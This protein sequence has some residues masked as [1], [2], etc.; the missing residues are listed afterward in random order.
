MIAV[1]IIGILAAT[2]IPKYLQYVLRSR[3]TEGLTMMAMAKNAEY[4]FFALNDCFVNVE[5]TP[6]GGTPSNVRQAWNSVPSG[7]VQLECSNPAPRSFDDLAVRPNY[8][9]VYYEYECRSR[10]SGPGGQTDEF[11][12]SAWGDLDGDGVFYELVYGTDF[13]NDNRTIPS[14]HGTVSFF[15]NDPVRISVGIY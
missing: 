1:A 13:D 7:N 2:A 4:A 5:P 12:C 9:N 3:Q 6:V 14:G 8:M 11:T 15:P 10:F